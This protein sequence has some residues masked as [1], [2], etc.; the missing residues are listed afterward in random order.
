MDGYVVWVSRCLLHPPVFFHGVLT[1][2]NSG[3][4]LDV[5]ID[6]FFIA[7]IGYLTIV[8]VAEALYRMFD[9]VLYS[10]NYHRFAAV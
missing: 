10:L 9:F 7:Y 8:Q 1:Y 4:F 6:Y 5:A 3:Y 2:I